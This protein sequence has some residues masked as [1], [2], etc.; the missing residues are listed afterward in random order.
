MKHMITCSQVALA[1]VR[2]ASH[3]NKTLNRIQMRRY[4]LNWVTEVNFLIKL[5]D[6]ST[7]AA[8]VIRKMRTARAL[9]H[10]S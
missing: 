8:V 9:S 5:E 2:A 3:T 10:F 1:R 4:L 7:K 6:S